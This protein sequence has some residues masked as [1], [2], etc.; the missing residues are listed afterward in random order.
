MS[1]AQESGSWPYARGFQ[2]CS[3]TCDPVT[4]KVQGNIPKWLEGVLYRTGSGTYKIPS[5]KNPEIVFSFDH[6][7]DGL[8]Q[9]H[10]FEI[11][12]GV[13]TYRSRNVAS[14]DEK[15]IE[16]NGR[17][18]ITKITFGQDICEN[19]FKKFF[20]VFQASISSNNLSDNPNSG[21]IAVT[22]TTSLPNPEVNSTTKNNRTLVLGTDANVLKS[23]DPITLEPIQNFSFK[24]F[25]PTLSGPMAP[26]HYQYDS[27][28]GEYFS[29]VSN[30]G[31]RPEFSIFS[32]KTDEETGKPITTILATIPSKLA[33][34]HSFS[35]TKKYIIFIL[36]QC[37]FAM[38]GAKILWERNIV[39]SFV[40]W[41]P[42]QK[43]HFYVID[44]KLKKHVATYTSPTFYCF[45]T[46]NAYDEGD[47][48]IIDLS[49]YKDNSIIFQLTINR[50][51]GSETI[52][53]KLPPRFDNGRLHRY[54]LC[55]ISNH[56]DSV[57]LNYGNDKFPNA[58]LVFATPE[59]LNVELPVVNFSR[60]YMKKYQYVYGISHSGSNPH[61]FFD[62][63]IKIDLNRTEDGS[64]NHKIWQQFGCIPSEP[65]FVPAPNAVEEDDGV[66]TSVVLDGTKNTSFLLILDAK[67]FKEIARAEM[68]LGTVVPYGFHG[69]WN[70]LD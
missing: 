3:E 10:R 53:D 55:N 19:I 34:L 6:W 43:T 38:G 13:V 9:V 27:E 56:L 66:I 52:A 36:W 21:N 65:I 59:D 30:T 28:T 2:N 63:L 37:D 17:L 49:Q 11:R 15:Y 70:N 12:N 51:S 64:F 47:D 46:I 26:A 57:D 18:P 45:H 48:V 67:S 8:G 54:K 4:L 35:M 39:R 62:R 61:I 20:T 22:L 69:L 29:F 23:I 14:E 31:P 5:K 44:R 68:E 41:D 7:F 40:P 58:E 1:S 42:N 25:H 50:L 32:I 24:K 16:E 33:Y 60:Y